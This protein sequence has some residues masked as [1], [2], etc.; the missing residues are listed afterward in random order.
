[1]H[2]LS[3][4]APSLKSLVALPYPRSSRVRG[5]AAVVMLWKPGAIRADPVAVESPN[6]NA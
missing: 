1:V 3:G 4:D 2:L 5:G 6:R